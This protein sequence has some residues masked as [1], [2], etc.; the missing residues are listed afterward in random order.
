MHVTSYL[1]THPD[2]FRIAGITFVP[3]ATDL[4]LTLDE[5]DDAS[6]AR[7][8]RGRAR[9][10]RASS[11]REVVGFLRTRPDLVALNAHV[12]QKAIEEG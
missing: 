8:D 12:R 3:A 4:R 9:G 7:R 5:P 10:A 6:A 2:E 11:W 1:Y